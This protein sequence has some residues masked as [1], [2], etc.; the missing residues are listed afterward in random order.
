M[1]GPSD[2][3]SEAATIMAVDV[4]RN[5]F[6]VA[7]RSFTPPSGMQPNGESWLIYADQVQTEDELV[8][9]QTDNKVAGENVLLDMAHRPNQVGRMIIEHDWRGAWGADTKYFIHRQPNGTRLERIYSTVQLRDPHLGTAWEN[10]TLERARY[11]KFSKS[12]ALD[13]ISSL[14]YYTPTIWHIT[15][16]ASDRYQRHL[17][18]K[19]KFQMQNK[20]TGR[21]ELIWKDLHQEDHLLDAECMVAIRAI[22]M[23]LISP[24]A[25]NV[26]IAA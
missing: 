3:S 9:L 2:I 7:I 6:W 18:S 22:Q 19:M 21:M 11:V 14:R 4:Q 26:A 25:E 16:N 13:L 8:K 12:G 17:N 20:R 1:Y 15:A 5:S 24:P 23:G 10:R